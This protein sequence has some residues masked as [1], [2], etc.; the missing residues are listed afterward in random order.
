M[1]TV[2]ASE[3]DWQRRALR[4]AAL[5]CSG[6]GTVDC[7]SDLTAAYTIVEHQ[8]SDL[9]LMSSGLATLPEFEVI[10]LLFKAVGTRCVLVTRYPEPTRFELSLALRF[11]LNCVSATSL[12]DAL[13]PS[14]PIS[15]TGATENDADS[16][17]S[18][19]TAYDNGFILIGAS[20]GGV[21]A[22]IQVLSHFPP[23]C[24]PTF[25]VQHTGPSFTSGL[26]RL[27]DS[28]VKP[29]VR[30]AFAGAKPETGHVYLAP[31]G[32]QHMILNKTP[33]AFV[34][35]A[36]GCA[37]QGHCPSVDHL[38]LSAVPHAKRVVAALLTG[39]GRDGADGLLSL[40][41]AG[42]HTVVQDERTS[43]V[44]GMPRAAMELGAADQ[45]LPVERIGPAL[46]LARRSK[47]SCR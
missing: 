10:T 5:A 32:S 30:E 43:A 16:G 19:P 17:A 35:F 39:M 45:Q 2:V 38:F 6:F 15:S 34:Q 44:Y 46:L 37:A 33:R 21:D 26:A 1:K 31:G 14:K 47:L 42:A 13:A 36:T 9:V 3:D 8:R 29:T 4:S 12:A 18:E 27:I 7:V 11:R 40:K 23:K 25:I 24:P 28:R 41:H 20:T 22:L